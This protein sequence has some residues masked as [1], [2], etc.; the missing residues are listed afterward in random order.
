MCRRDVYGA[1][2]VVEDEHPDACTRALTQDLGEH[3]RH[4]AWRAI[5]HLQGDRLPC[6]TEVVPEAGK[7]FVAVLRH[8]DAVAG[9]EPRAGGHR[10][11]RRE[12]RF[13][14]ADRDSI[15]RDAPDVPNGRA[16]R[17]VEEADERKSEDDDEQRRA[18]DSREN[19][20]QPVLPRRSAGAGDGT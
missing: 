2:G 12:L 13:A 20:E 9:R 1:E 5:I 7:G 19:G 3:I 6:R 8:L 15:R 10:R 4:P 14:D 11:H 16:A 17:H 18:A